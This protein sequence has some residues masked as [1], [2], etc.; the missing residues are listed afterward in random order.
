MVK[1]VSEKTTNKHTQMQHPG[2]MVMMMMIEVCMD[3]NETYNPCGL[4]PPWGAI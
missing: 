3:V 4:L 2:C 1:F